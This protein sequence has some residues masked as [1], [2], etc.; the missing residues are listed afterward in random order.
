MMRAA[1]C[2]RSPAFFF[3]LQ[4]ESFPNILCITT[5]ISDRNHDNS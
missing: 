3:R 2:G 5:S 1:P 4:L